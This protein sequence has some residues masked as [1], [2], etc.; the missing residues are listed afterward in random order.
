MFD[1]FG[2]YLVDFKKNIGGEISGKHYAVVL[3]KIPRKILHSLSLLLPV[4][5]K[6][7]SIE[8]E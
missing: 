3:S 5:K 1:V 7:K 6:V 8:E 4:K 2:V